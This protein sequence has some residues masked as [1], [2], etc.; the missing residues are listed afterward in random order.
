MYYN[1]ED[2]NGSRIVSLETLK[3][4]D[5]AD[6]PEPMWDYIGVWGP[7]KRYYFKSVVRGF[8]GSWGLYVFDLKSRKYEEI[9]QFPIKAVSLPTWSADG[10]LMAWT[11]KEPVRQLWMMTNYE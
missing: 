6:M 4:S 5:L 10:R 1:S 7:D 3:I 9:R 2:N 11:E 8:S